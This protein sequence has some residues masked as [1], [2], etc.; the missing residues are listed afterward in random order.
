MI[1]LNAKLAGAG[2]PPLT[3]LATAF[4]DGTRLCQ[5]LEVFSEETI[6]YHARPFLRVQRMENVSTALNFISAHGV[7]L[8]N[9]GAE[10]VVDGNLKLILGMIW[11]L[12][13]RFS[14]ATIEYVLASS[15]RVL[16]RRRSRTLLRSPA[17]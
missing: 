3:S 14:I 11:T 12:V 1:R 8:T 13:L 7:R 4:S 15:V 9:I 17:A 10:D 16:Q 5:L 2:L 6:R